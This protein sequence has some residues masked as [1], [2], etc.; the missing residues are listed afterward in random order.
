M[1]SK[2][3]SLLR[4]VGRGGYQ[5]AGLVKLGTAAAKDSGPAVPLKV[6]FSG[7]YNRLVMIHLPRALE[8]LLSS[9]E[10]SASSLQ[11]Q[12]CYLPE[13]YCESA[14]AGLLT[15]GRPSPPIH[16]GPL[17][18]TGC[19]P[20]YGPP[21]ND[22]KGLLRKPAPYPWRQCCCVSTNV[23][24]AGLGVISIQKFYVFHFKFLKTLLEVNTEM[25]HSN[26]SLHQQNWGRALYR[27]F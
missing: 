12:S 15:R 11:W 10:P 7:S 17:S 16:S 19:R 21:S 2:I 13:D 5:W 26:A 22:P 3:I 9:S 24:S 14:C 4:V 25:C 20:L 1:Q 8:Q 27:D 18:Y 23:I 6:K